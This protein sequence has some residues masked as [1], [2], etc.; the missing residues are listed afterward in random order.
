MDEMVLPYFERTES[1]QNPLLERRYGLD[2]GQF[3]PVMDEFYGL[4]GWDAETGWP[5]RERLRQLDLA[6]VYEPMV[7]GASEARE[8][9]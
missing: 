6:D 7:E 9:S 5:T 4:K 3:E 2:R 1:Y 8:R